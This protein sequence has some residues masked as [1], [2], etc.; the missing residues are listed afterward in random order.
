MTRESELWTVTDAVDHLGLSAD[1]LRDLSARDPLPAIARGKGGAPLYR[2]EDL[3]Q[4]ARE[5]T[6]VPVFTHAV[7]L[8]EDDEH[9]SAVAEAYIADGLRRGEGCLSA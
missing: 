2:R 3:E 9:L 5:H 4:L 8:Y 6:G 1:T 7:Q